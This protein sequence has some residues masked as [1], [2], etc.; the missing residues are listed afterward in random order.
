VLNI[1]QLPRYIQDTV[2]VIEA[3][4][5]KK[6]NI[7]IVFCFGIFAWTLVSSLPNIMESLFKLKSDNY[8]FQSGYFVH[9]VE[10]VK[11]V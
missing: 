11:R 4:L 7:Q 10:M 1:D 2:T 5:E 3:Y 9:F 6:M 8:V